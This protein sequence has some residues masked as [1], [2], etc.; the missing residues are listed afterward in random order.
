MNFQGDSG[1]PLQ[2]SNNQDV[3][4]TYKQIGVVSFGAKECG[5]KGLP[6]MDC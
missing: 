4:C 1:G 3:R 5:T 6:G 2:I